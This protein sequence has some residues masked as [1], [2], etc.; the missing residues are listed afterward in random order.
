LSDSDDIVIA[1]D[2]GN[3]ELLNWSRHSVARQADI[4]KDSGV[5]TCIR[6]GFDWKYLGWAFLM[7]LD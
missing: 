7:D 6:E 5:Q 1:Q 3:G 2:G 4:G